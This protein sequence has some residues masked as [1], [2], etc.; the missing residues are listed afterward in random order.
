ML[1]RL[2]RRL[3][4]RRLVRA[5][6][7]VRCV[8]G[9]APMCDRQEYEGTCPEY[10]APLCDRHDCEV[11]L[12]GACTHSGR[13]R[14]AASLVVSSAAQVRLSTAKASHMQGSVGPESHASVL[15][16]V[17]VHEAMGFGVGV[18]NRWLR[19]RREEQRAAAHLVF[20][21]G[22]RSLQTAAGPAMRQ[23]CSGQRRRACWHAN[24]RGNQPHLGTC[25][26]DQRPKQ[27]RSTTGNVFVNVNHSL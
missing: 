27:L 11:Y 12:P 1:A 14:A 4:L 5:L 6:R 2:A 26:I 24:R 3:R 15:T 17:P 25:C 10:G 16:L 22:C 19:W 13:T 8:N 20:V 18:P 9:R 23:L 21:L 7:G